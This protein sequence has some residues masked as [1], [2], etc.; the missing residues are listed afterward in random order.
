MNRLLI[1]FVEG[2]F[3]MMFIFFIVFFIKQQYIIQFP[4]SFKCKRVGG[5][6]VVLQQ[7]SIKMIA[8]TL[9]RWSQKRCCYLVVARWVSA[10][11]S[12][13]FMIPISSRPFVVS[14]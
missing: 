6:I 2:L 7:C 5:Y 14:L 10:Q 11:C 8:T 4:D 12:S 1:I 9:K 3:S 13:F